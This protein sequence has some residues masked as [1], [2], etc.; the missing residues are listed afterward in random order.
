M[1]HKTTENTEGPVIDEEIITQC[2]HSLTDLRHSGVDKLI[3]LD[4][5][6]EL[7]DAG[8]IP[9]DEKPVYNVAQRIV[10]T[11]HISEGID[12]R[13]AK[14]RQCR[15]KWS[16]QL[17]EQACA[18][19]NL[20]AIT[21]DKR[22]KSETDAVSDLSIAVSKIIGA[23]AVHPETNYRFN[24][25]KTGVSFR[26]PPSPNKVYMP[27]PVCHK[28][29]PDDAEIVAQYGRLPEMMV[30]ADHILSAVDRREIAKL[31]ESTETVDVPADNATRKPEDLV[32]M[33]YRQHL[34]IVRAIGTRDPSLYRH[35]YQLL[36]NMAETIPRYVYAKAVSKDLLSRDQWLVW[37]GTHFIF[38]PW[39]Q[40][41]DEA[42]SLDKFREAM[43]QLD[44]MLFAYRTLYQGITGEYVCTGIYRPSECKSE[45]VEFYSMD[46]AG[47]FRCTHRA[48]RLNRG[49]VNLR[50]TL[51]GYLHD[52][53]LRKEPPYARDDLFILGCERNWGYHDR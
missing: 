4:R 19:R 26:M 44:D 31:L 30:C 1:T 25:V 33:D 29:L 43:G 22:R 18:Y 3:A 53:T 50:M 14:K 12:R 16:L 21:L 39:L 2:V 9:S 46:S 8:I 24:F 52:Y 34:P 47:C 49:L 17:Y 7:R 27:C 41:L 42:A 45:S 28:N 48:K 23:F 13:A 20:A 10:K 5:A 6:I 40:P 36:A 15:Y 38:K 32:A 11:E 51:N 35:I 37:L